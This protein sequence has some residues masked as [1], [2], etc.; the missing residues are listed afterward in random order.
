MSK[1]VYSANDLDKEVEVKEPEKKEE[2][3]PEDKK[4]AP[5]EEEEEEEEPLDKP[6]DKKKPTKKDEDPEEE[7]EEEEDSA[8]K[9]PEAKKK[10]EKK[11]DPDDED[12]DDEEDLSEEDKTFNT[13]LAGKLEKKYGIKSLKELEET[14]SVVDDAI[15]GQK[16][17]E[18]EIET[19]KKAEPKLKFP[20]KN[21]EAAYEFISELPKDMQPERMITLAELRA[22]DI[23]NADPRHILRQK[24]ILEHP[25]LTREEVDLKFDRYF[26]KK[27]TINPDNFDTDTER[28]EE[29]KL[30]KITMKSDVAKAKAYL[31]TQKDKFKAPE[32]EEEKPAEVSE[33]I[34]KG[35]ARNVKEMNEFLDGFDKVVLPMEGGGKFK[36]TLTDDDKKSVRS[37][38]EWIKNASLYSEKGE[39]KNFDAKEHAISAFL[40]LHHKRVLPELWKQASVTASKKSIEDLSEKGPTRKVKGPDADKM[41]KTEEEQ[42]EELLK[43]KESKKKAARVAA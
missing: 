11:E 13:T 9:K 14:L 40:A 35:I 32:K 17:L 10:E 27:Y 5:E 37:A 21:H 3:N 12:E 33:P 29:E 6:V 18:E 25:E 1:T 43:N 41:P 2:K 39:L 20:S 31:A 22:I 36:F 30:A 24:Y 15:K 7:E 38:M 26:K 16:I 34:K 23:D 28:Q 19:L 42:W 4:E 8:T